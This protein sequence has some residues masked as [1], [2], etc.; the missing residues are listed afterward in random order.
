MKVWIVK[1]HVYATEEL[2]KEA[3][4]YVRYCDE[5]G[6]GYGLYAVTEAEVETEIKERVPEEYRKRYFK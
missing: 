1:G 6:G 3:C 5:M 4:A 2:A